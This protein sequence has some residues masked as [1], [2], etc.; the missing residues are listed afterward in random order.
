LE[1]FGQNL[2]Y[3]GGLPNGRMGLGDLGRRVWHG[4]LEKPRRKRNWSN[5]RRQDRTSLETM[6][7]RARPEV[8]RTMIYLVVY[9]A[10]LYCG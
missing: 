5:G 10:L 3:R 7:A 1:G 6:C 9:A 2:D 4:A 8:L